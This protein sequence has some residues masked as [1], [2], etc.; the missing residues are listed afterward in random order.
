MAEKH[1]GNALFSERSI[2]FAEQLTS[3]TMAKQSK[4]E[5]A[6]ARFQAALQMKQECLAELEQSMKVAYEQRTGKP[7]DHFFAL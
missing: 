5:E 7:A 6:L 2:N 4:R 3:K 1:K